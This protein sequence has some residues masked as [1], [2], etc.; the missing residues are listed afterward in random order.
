MNK[1]I[2]CTSI[3]AP[4]IAIEKY[5]AMGEWTLIVVG[6]L[7]TPLGYALKNGI[8]L[9]P[10]DQK[11]M[12]SSLSEL[13][14]WNC[15]QRRNFG[16]LHALNLGADA[17]AIVDDDNI[18]LDNWGQELL[19][20]QSV[21]STEFLT[22][23]EA[24]D[25]IG[26]TNYPHLWHR[27]FPLELINSRD[28]DKKIVK[29]IVPDIQADFWNGDPDIDAICRLEHRPN[30]EFNNSCFPFSSNKISPF[31]SQNTV[32]SRNVAME[33]FLYP[34][35]GRMDDIWAS[36]YVQSK[37]FK[38]IYNKPTVFQDRNEH[39]LIV[40][41]KKEYVGYENN[42]QLLKDLNSN[43]DN[44]HRYIPEKSYA[45]WGEYRKLIN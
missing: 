19:I 10:K 33:Y 23:E 18:P 39:N 37:G 3:N 20:G 1:F 8:Y 28:Y 38:V 35:I 36:Y 31:N 4:T 45:A 44:I 6:D 15:I 5:D 25:P 12:G 29:E 26:A 2:V 32:I 21:Q 30:C 17:I 43:P 40:D 22:T 11:K 13:I 9:N 27:G 42:L 41:M 24:F 16:L 7:K 14:G 34:H